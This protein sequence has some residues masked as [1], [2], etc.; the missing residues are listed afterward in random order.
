MPSDAEESAGLPPSGAVAQSVSDAKLAAMLAQVGANI[1]KSGILLPVPSVSWVDDWYLGSECD[2]QLCPAPVPFFP[3]VHEELTRLWRAPFTADLA[4]QV[5][6]PSL[7]LMVG[8]PGGIRT[9]HRWSMRLWCIYA[10]KMPP[11][12]RIVPNSHQILS[13]P[14]MTGVPAHVRTRLT[15]PSA[16]VS[17]AS[18]ED[19][20]LPQPS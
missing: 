14:M 20:Q 5:L 1:G 6:P 11:P 3:E 17:V 18:S 12:G 4:L 13:P 9:F 15:Q 7:L 10:C 16:Q 2:S 8:R 19:V